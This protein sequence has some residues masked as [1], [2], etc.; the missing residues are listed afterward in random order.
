MIEKYG[1][2]NT[3]T[4]KLLRV[5]RYSYPEDSDDLYMYTSMDN[6]DCPLYLVDSLTIA[7]KSLANNPNR[8]NTSYEHPQH[9]DNKMNSY[10]IPVKI[11]IQIDEKVL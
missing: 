2:L 10:C 3:A 6:N 4:D 7:L 1:I 11:T 8:W 9:L 5:I